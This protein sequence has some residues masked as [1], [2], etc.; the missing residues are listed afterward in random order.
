MNKSETYKLE[1]NTNEIELQMLESS[2][3][4]S[5]ILTYLDFKKKLDFVKE[6]M[7]K[8]SKI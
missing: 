5:L 1:N 8:N 3:I 2:F 4:Y 6:M 7:K